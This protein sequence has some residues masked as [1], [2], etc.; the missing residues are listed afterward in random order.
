MYVSPLFP[1]LAFLNAYA[2]S[3]LALACAGRLRTRGLRTGWNWLVGGAISLGCGIWGMHFIGMLGYSSGEG[4]PRFDLALTGVSLVVAV[5][6]VGFGLLVTYLHPH[7][8]TLLA[9]GIVTGLGISAMHYIG[10]AAMHLAGTVSYTP[11]TV[12]LSVAIAVVTATAALGTA[13]AS[14]GTWATVGAGGLMA[15]SISTMHYTGMMA[16]TVSPNDQVVVRGV[17]GPSL[18]VPLFLC[19]SL[20]LL[21]VGFAVVTTPLLP[22]DDFGAASAG[23]AFSRGF[24]R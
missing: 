11:R 15:I 19:F 5:A 8:Y 2:G 17:E 13:L 9:G 24:G 12:T 3:V 7:W 23:H 4:R 16:V 18:I 6:I 14:L 22:E 1:L 20:E 21:M 10:M